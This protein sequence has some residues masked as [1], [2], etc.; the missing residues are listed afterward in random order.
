M[1]ESG[2]Q[3]EGN[4]AAIRL[5]GVT[6]RFE[7]RSVLED[8][9]LEVRRGEKVVLVGPPGCGKTTVLRC[10][11]GFVVPQQGEVF[12]E[13]E[14]VTAQSVWE[15]RRRMA[16]VAQDVELG[17][18]TVREALERPMRF[19]AN[20]HLRGNLQQE[21]SALS[22]GQRQLV[23]LIGAILLDRPIMLLD[24]PTA[25]L[26]EATARAVAEY[27]RQREDLTVLAVTHHRHRF[28]VGARIVRMGE[29]V[30]AGDVG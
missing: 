17:P 10:V 4:E 19:R 21:T 8:F 25:N 24:E 28:D 30:A 11:L 9:C 18:G 22:G 13:G 29:E 15:L 2:G 3:L 14:Q 1:T 27:F 7:G 12:V 5:V 23:A 6:V 20:V 16:Y 26:D